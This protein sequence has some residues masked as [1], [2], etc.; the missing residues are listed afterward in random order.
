[1][2]NFFTPIFNT[3]SLTFGIIALRVVIAVVLGGAIGLERGVRN[4]PAGFRTHILVCVGACLAML[5]NQFVFDAIGTGTDPTRIG[6]QVISGIGFLGVGTI[7][8]AGRGTIKGLTTAAGLWA[9]GAIGLAVGIG[10]YAGAVVAGIV[11]LVVLGLFPALENLVYRTSRRLILHIEVSSLEAEAAFAKYIADTGN[12]VKSKHI[13]TISVPGD[14]V[15]SR[16][17]IQ[18]KHDADAEGFVS[19]LASLP[20]VIQIEVQ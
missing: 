17:T 5:T 9:A 20:G 19:Q 1:M 12:L 2:D 14:K 7:F 15:S 6:A 13:A 16:Y 3:E 18:M 8:M 4:H 11:V 10:F